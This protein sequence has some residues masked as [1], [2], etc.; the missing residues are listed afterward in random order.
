MRRLEKRR[1]I[2]EIAVGEVRAHYARVLQSLKVGGRREVSHHRAG[3]G[4]CD[5]LAHIEVETDVF[6]GAFVTHLLNDT[7]HLRGAVG[8]S[9]R[10]RVLLDF[11]DELGLR[12]FTGLNYEFLE[13]RDAR[14]LTIGAVF[15]FH[16]PSW[17]TTRRPSVV[18]QISSSTASNPAFCAASRAGMEFSITVL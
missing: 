4:R 3:Q 7:N 13:S 8:I 9:L 5:L 6:G 1:I 16:F 17:F 14:K 11:Y 10:R 12:I 2:K 18:S 15:P